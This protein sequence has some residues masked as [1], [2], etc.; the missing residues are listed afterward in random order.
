[1]VAYGP[2]L[3]LVWRVR[4]TPNLRLEAIDEHGRRYT[5]LESGE[6]ITGRWRAGYRF[7]PA[8]EP[9]ARE[10]R[11]EAT[12][13]RWGGFEVAER[14]FVTRGATA[15]PWRFVVALPATQHPA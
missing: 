6:G 5:A 14:G 3:G 13:C 8:L 2:I 10:L 4:D 1:L 7:A 12:E 9:T 11:L 15:G